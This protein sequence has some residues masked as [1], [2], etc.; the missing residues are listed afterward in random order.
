M[1]TERKTIS[2]TNV[3]YEVRVVLENLKLSEF[4]AAKGRT[5]KGNF[6]ISQEMKTDGCSLNNN[7]CCEN[8]RNFLNQMNLRE[9]R[10]SCSPRE[11]TTPK[12]ELR[13]GVS[14]ILK[15]DPTHQG[16]LDRIVKIFKLRTTHDGLSFEGRP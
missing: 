3:N 6:E 1:F 2:P 10:S 12:Y 14:K 5:Q 7:I 4:P 16:S 15:S 13:S 8:K 11:Q 9:R